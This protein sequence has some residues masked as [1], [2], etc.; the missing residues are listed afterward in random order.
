MAAANS[1]SEF[2]SD[3]DKIPASSGHAASNL[4]QDT[5]G[6]R[7]R[8]TAGSSSNQ[9]HSRHTVP[10]LTQAVRQGTEGV[11]IQIV[12]LLCLLSFLLAYF[13]F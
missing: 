4:N 3:E 2:A 10:E 9:P 5:G 12:A 6:L 11:P 8:K 1:A 13:F 7:Q